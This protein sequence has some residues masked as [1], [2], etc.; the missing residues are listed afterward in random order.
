VVQQLGRGMLPCRGGCCGVRLVLLSTQYGVAVEVLAVEV[1]AV[2]RVGVWV[3]RVQLQLPLGMVVGEL[4]AAAPV[5][6]AEEAFWLI[7]CLVV[8][9]WC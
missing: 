8:W 9:F 3:L 4:A 7:G 2:V 1:L 5:D 6:F